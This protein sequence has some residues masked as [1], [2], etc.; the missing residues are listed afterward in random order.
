[1]TANQDTIAK[2]TDIDFLPARYREHTAQRKGQAWRLS[3]LILLGMMLPVASFYQLRVRSSLQKELAAIQPQ[4]AAIDAYQTQ[5]Q[6]LQQKQQRLESMARVIAYLQHPWPRSQLLSAL[7]PELPESVSLTSIQIE[8]MNSGAPAAAPGPKNPHQET[9]TE[10]AEL[11]PAEADLKQLRERHDKA[12]V[13]VMLAGMATDPGQLHEYLGRLAR[14]RLFTKTE[15]LSLASPSAKAPAGRKAG[16]GSE[17]RAM[18]IVAQ[19]PGQPQ[20]PN[21]QADP[22][23]PASAIAGRTP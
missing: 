4:C 20:G 17:F 22:K 9:G 10:T 23:T 13:V 11:R 5:L 1:M 3:T 7:L 16:D 15:L 19:G 2:E 8:E 21:P 6:G 18:L 12:Q 14:H